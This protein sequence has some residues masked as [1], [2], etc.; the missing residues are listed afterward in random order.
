MSSSH[1]E[2]SLRVVAEPLGGGPLAQL[3]MANRGPAWVGGRPDS[4]AAWR[5]RAQVVGRTEARA[6]AACGDGAPI[7]RDCVARGGVVVT[8]GQQPGLFGGPLY[9]LHKALTA[10]EFA[11]ALQ[12]ATGTAAVPV[13]WAATDDA[14]FAEASATWVRAPDGARR[15]VLEGQPAENIPLSRVALPA[16]DG[17]LAALFEAGGSSVDLRFL[18][19]AERAYRA[20]ETVGGAYVHLLR[21]LLQPLGIAVLDASHQSVYEA[22][23]E[24]LIRA[25]E[26]H[27]AVDAALERR[28]REIVSLGLAPQVPRVDGL[29]T[30]FEWHDQRGKQ[31][32]PREGAGAAVQRAS[33]ARLSPNVLLRPVVERAILP[34]V[35][36]VAGPGELAYFPQARAV[37]EAMELEAPVAM[38]RWSATIIEPDVARLLERHGVTRQALVDAHGVERRLARA[39]APAA[40]LRALADLRQRLDDEGASLKSLAAAHEAALDPRVIDGAT[41]GMRFRVDRLERRLLARVKRREADLMR[42]VRV[43][44]GALYPGGAR[45]ER[46]LNCLPL[47]AT[48]GAPLLEAL[49]RSARRHAQALVAGGALPLD[50]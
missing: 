22:S 38:P 13:F 31:R 41:R 15:L 26:R 50:E 44:Q 42:D 27:N 16:M 46:G 23:R 2:S 8:T 24:V 19:M 32:V 36:Y 1:P 28:E 21:Q 12:E 49:R 48:H 5:A 18:A 4:A 7:I 10:L 34:T 35:A 29:T 3:G 25:L 20:G 43:M 14:D 45:Q 39:A 17:L 11:R 37:A 9:T 40:L 47:L 30:V 33:R 6:L